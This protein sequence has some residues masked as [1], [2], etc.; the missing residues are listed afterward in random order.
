[1]EDEIPKYIIKNRRDATSLDDLDVENEQI[2]RVSYVDSAWGTFDVEAELDQ[3]F[4]TLIDL[5]K[6]QFNLI[7]LIK[8]HK[9]HGIVTIDGRE[10]LV[11]YN[12]GVSFI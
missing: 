8:P 4:Y 12:V 6:S 5:R 10:S 2:N 7:N 9:T 11:V 1:M 3:T